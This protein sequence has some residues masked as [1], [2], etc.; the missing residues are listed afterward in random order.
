MDNV[1][2]PIPLTDQHRHHPKYLEI[3]RLIRE[4]GY[5]AIA[6]HPD[7][8][9]QLQYLQRRRLLVPL[10][11]GHLV[12]AGTEDDPDLRIRVVSAWHPDGVLLGAAAARATFAPDI[13][14]PVIVMATS[15]KRRSPDGV[16]LIRW[17]VPDEHIGEHNGLR[18]TRPAL[19]ALDLSRDDDGATIDEVLRRGLATLTHLHRAL[20]ATPYRLGNPVRRF[21]VD[22]S[23][24]VPWSPAERLGHRILR[25]AGIT[26]WS[27]N[28]RVSLPQGRHGFID[29]AFDELKI[30]V[31][32]DG[33]GHHGHTENRAQFE[34]DR[35]KRASI[36][37]DGWVVIPL[38]YLQLTEQLDWVLDVIGQTIRHRTAWL[39]GGRRRQ[40]EPH[41][42]AA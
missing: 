40:P 2:R 6:D 38:T 34:R 16:R 26:G 10:C 32:I 37:A 39:R 41:T 13:D 1:T 23:R 17:T 29:I 33:Y 20:R 19:T 28:L 8:R 22:D 4:Q 12:R 18:F 15:R 36:V 3:E 35:W 27:T 14:V 25:A 9:H 24:D 21:M 31:E 7:L 30:A 42:T 5:I 11:P